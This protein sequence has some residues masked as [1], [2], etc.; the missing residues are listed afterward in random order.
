MPVLI[1]RVAARKHPIALLAPHHI[2]HHTSAPG[3][4]NMMRKAGFV[5]MIA[6]ALTF[7]AEVLAASA[8]AP[9]PA[10]T[11][12]VVWVTCAQAKQDC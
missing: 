5:L 11:A 6:A 12:T 8:P 4:V 1:F 2:V 7:S 10:S 9:A 3:I